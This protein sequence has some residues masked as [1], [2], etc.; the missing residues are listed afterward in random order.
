[1]ET[2]IPVDIDKVQRLLLTDGWH[3]V[4]D[5]SC[6]SISAARSLLVPGRWSKVASR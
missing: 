3:Q 5:G 4:K 2:F 1:M 6:I